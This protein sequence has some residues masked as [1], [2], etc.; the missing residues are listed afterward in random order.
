MT[1]QSSTT[2]ETHARHATLSVTNLGGIDSTAVEFAPGVTVLTGRN[3]TNRTSL[4]RALNGAL[5]GTAATLKSDADDGQVTLA[6]GDDEFTRKY[7][8]TGAGI[9]AD[10]TPYTD[11]DALVDGF[12]TLF[13]DNP[14]RRAVERGDDLHDAIMR[15]VDTEA[16]EQRIRDLRQEKQ[17]LE[18]ERDRIGARRDT[19]PELKKRRQTLTEQIATIDEKLTDLRNEVADINADAETAEEAE[20]LMDDLDVRRQNL[21]ETEDEIELVESELDALGDELE[22]TRA[23]RARLPAETN[24]RAAI[25]SELESLRAQK[26]QLDNTIASLQTIIEFNDN[27]LDEDSPSLPGVDPD[28]DAVTAALAPDEAQN[29]VCW[30]CGSRVERG[31]IADRLDDLRAVIEEKQADRADLTERIDDLEEDLQSVDEHQRRKDELDRTIE[32]TERKLAQRE[33]R[34]EELEA[35]ASDLREQIQKLEADVTE[36]EALRESDLLETYEQISDLEYDRGQRQRDL[37]EVD[38][39][40]A[41]IE[42]LSDTSEI[43]A[44]LGE[45]TQELERE[46]T[47]IADLETDAVEQ[48]NAHMDEILEVLAFENLARVWIER[49]TD[50]SGRGPPETVFDLHV[51]RKDEAGTIYE[52]VVEHLSE[53]EREVVGLVVALAGYLAHEAYESVP[54]MLLDS[55]EAIDADRIANLVEYFADYAPHLAVALLPEDAEA[56]PADYERLTA[57]ALNS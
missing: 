27:L 33:N 38:A 35:T 16:I 40:I 48:F 39:E 57:D 6:L 26:R 19:L 52:D 41:E 12:V 31:A 34:L 56:L 20:A 3:A 14:A 54:F 37:E 55:L 9:T 11:A 8:R 32:Q 25:D 29:V 10:G 47:R 4:L 24:D 43:E 53:S 1:R 44:Q 18:A 13:E 7:T 17:D 42:A 5:G 30:T 21:R 22:E 50:D 45:V 36:T 15:P 2:A 51:V 49:R 23:D 28:D 46:R